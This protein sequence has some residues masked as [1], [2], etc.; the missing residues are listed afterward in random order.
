MNIDLDNSI[1]TTVCSV[2]ITKGVF[3]ATFSS[4]TECELYAKSVV[5]GGPAA[6]SYSNCSIAS[7]CMTF[8]APFGGSLKGYN[9]SAVTA[10][11]FSSAT[12]VFQSKPDC[13]VALAD[14]D[15]YCYNADNKLC[16]NSALVMTGCELG[17]GS[18]SIPVGE[19]ANFDFLPY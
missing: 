6:Y 15:I 9:L 2:N 10:Q 16:N 12:L 18:F 5:I 1:A 13:D 14:G 8:D 17:G 3:V 11:G 7:Y 4:A 19:V